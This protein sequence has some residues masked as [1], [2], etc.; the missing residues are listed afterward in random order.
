MTTAEAE[1]ALK[2][3]KSQVA[4]REVVTAGNALAGVAMLVRA[5]A[6]G[7][8]VRAVVLIGWAV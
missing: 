4:G 7:L 1:K 8:Q 3:C 5:M 2:G 6:L